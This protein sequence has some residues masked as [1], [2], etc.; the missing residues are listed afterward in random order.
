MTAYSFEKLEK[1]SSLRETTT[2]SVIVKA[3]LHYS[4]FNTAQYYCGPHVETVK[5]IKLFGR[6]TMLT[7]VK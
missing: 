2:F 5:C 1:I 3:H 7:K 6:C 4:S